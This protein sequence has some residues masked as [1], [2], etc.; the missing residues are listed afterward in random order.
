MEA[1]YLEVVVDRVHDDGRVG[2]GGAEVRRAARQVVE[3]VAGDGVRVGLADQEHRPVVLAVA[4]GGPAGD[5]VELVVGDGD[6]ARGAPAR[7]D[8]LAA[9]EGELVVVDPDVV[10]AVQGDGV[11]APDELGVEL[12][13]QRV[14]VCRY[15]A[16]RSW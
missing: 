2:H 10:A 1:P 14:S 3:P 13:L 7:H 5:A 9:D 6:A 12:L 11:A 8:H 4:A 15:V 16:S